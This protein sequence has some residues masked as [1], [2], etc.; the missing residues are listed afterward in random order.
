MFDKVRNGAYN[1]LRT[2]KHTTHLY[3]TPKEVTMKIKSLKIVLEIDGSEIEITVPASQLKVKSK[4]EKPKHIAI[5][6]MVKRFVDSLEDK[7]FVNVTALHE[8]LPN[9]QNRVIGGSLSALGYDAVT[10]KKINGVNN[11]IRY[12]SLT[13][14][15]KDAK[16][17]Y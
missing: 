12:C 16:A 7:R 8:K 5:N 2:I 14:S 9:I 17:L 6:D 4:D 15:E 11:Y 3:C 10:R 13:H 1:S